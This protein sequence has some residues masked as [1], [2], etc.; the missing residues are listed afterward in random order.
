[1]PRHLILHAG[2]I[3]F[4]TAHATSLTVREALSEPFE[5]D[6]VIKSDKSA[7]A[8]AD[9][10]GKGI[11]GE[12]KTTISS[13]SAPRFWQGIVSD[14]EQSPDDGGRVWTYR[15]RA[16]PWLWF[17]TRRANCRI[18]P[19]K[20]V[21]EIVKEVIKDAGFDDFVDT[22]GL[23][24]TYQAREYTVQYRESDFN[25]IS[26][27]LEDEGIYYYFTH[28]KDKHT[29][30]LTDGIGGHHPHA[31]Y[32]K[33]PIRFSQNSGGATGEYVT[34]WSSSLEVASS[35][36]TLADYDYGAASDKL[37]AEKTVA[38]SKF[39]KL[40]VYD[41][42]GNPAWKSNK[43]N[44]SDLQQRAAT[45]L[46]ELQSGA[47]RAEGRGNV[48]GIAAGCLF[49]FGNP[50]GTAGGEHN[51]KDQ[52][53]EYLVV[54]AEHVITDTAGE[55]VRTTGPVIGAR[56]GPVSE[57]DTSHVV[58]FEAI[59]S[60]VQYRPPR[61]TLKPVIQGPQTATVTGPKGEDKIHTDD[62]GRIQVMFHWSRKNTDEETDPPP[63]C[64]LR[65]AQIWAGPGY[66]AFVL[67]RIGHEVIV[68]FLE[69]DP[70][71]PLVT[72][73]VYNG[74]NKP[75]F[76]MPGD[77][78]KAGLKTRSSVGGGDD[79]ANELVFD[80][81]KGSELVRLH[82]QKDL[83]IE[84]ENNEDRKVDKNRKTEI[85]EEDEEKVGKSQKID[86][87]EN[88]TLTVGGD[89]TEEVSGKQAVTVKKD[90]TTDVKMNQTVTVSQNYKL[91]ANQGI[92]FECG[93]SKISMA[94]D[95]TISIE[96]VQ[97]NIKGSMAVNI[98]SDMQMNMKGLM[99]KIEGTVQTEVKG[100]ML[101]LSG[102][103]M[104]QLKGAL[105]M[106]G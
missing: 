103:A 7:L 91:T 73:S 72:G 74:D 95:G 65:V 42:P 62:Q 5:L 37:E 18:F 77:K 96:G 32:A 81:N 44:T 26:R 89:Q 58:D 64:Y 80:D 29:L 23:S 61:V 48:R 19:G 66:G 101:Q 6:F 3:P 31:G 8:L 27:L 78:T 13:S 56:R 106:I 1:M 97:I 84:V 70:D 16:V 55:S 40:A 86:I 76:A 69:G 35:K 49:K 47:V 17:L 38:G 100:L 105:T 50:D 68:S 11:A 15:V 10:I 9:I 75:P 90:Q 83:K 45:R 33:V 28:A 21:P 102:D 52:N 85:V 20:T 67:P 12:L 59:P 79:D 93:A 99:T 41:F 88:Q 4:G 71:R 104:A 25:F 30:M 54:S 39:A 2:S 92:V 60:S 98:A 51:R 22:A 36:Y 43:L 94:P 14:V 24:R 63:S 53:V 34:E 82:A 57:P 87:K 46:A